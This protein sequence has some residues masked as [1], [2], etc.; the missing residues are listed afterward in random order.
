LNGDGYV[1]PEEM[2]AVHAQHHARGSK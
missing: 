2:K 1:T